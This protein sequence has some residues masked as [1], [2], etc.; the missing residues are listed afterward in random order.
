MLNEL[1]RTQLLL[2]PE[3]MEKLAHSRVAV[4]GIGGVGGYTVEALARSGI[5]ALDLIEALRCTK[6]RSLL[7]TSFKLLFRRFLFVISSANIY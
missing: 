7:S 6:T 5:G 3:A 4:F 2:G 1:S